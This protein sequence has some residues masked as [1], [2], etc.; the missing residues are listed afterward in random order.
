ML[1]RFAAPTGGRIEAG[2]RGA[3][4]R[5]PAFDLAAWRR[6]LAWVPQHPYLF[7]GTVASNIALGCPGASAADIA[8]AAALAGAAEFIAVAAP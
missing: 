2:A 3:A 6:Q 1:L 8:R 4:D 7:D 5:Y